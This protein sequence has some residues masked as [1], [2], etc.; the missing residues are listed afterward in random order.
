[1]HQAKNT[2]DD[3]EDNGPE[4]NIKKLPVCARALV[5]DVIHFDLSCLDFLHKLGEGKSYYSD[6]LANFCL[7]FILQADLVQFEPASFAR[8]QTCVA[9][10]QL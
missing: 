4:D 7:L 1:M 9:I 10:V 8:L 6:C 5:K 2:D 3:Q